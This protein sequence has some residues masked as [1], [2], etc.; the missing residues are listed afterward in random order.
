MENLKQGLGCLLLDVRLPD[1]SGLTLQ[2]LLSDTGRD[3]PIII[4][5]GHGD[6]SMAVKAM[7]QGAFDFIEKP[8]NDQLLLDRIRKA[9]QRD[10]QS[11]ESRLTAD[12]INSL[13]ATLTRRER[14]VM[15]LVVTG[16]SNK[17]IAEQL[18]VSP[19]TVEVHRAH[20]MK[21]MGA[22]SVA[23][24]VRLSLLTLRGGS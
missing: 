14:E 18:Q 23:D 15:D 21:K 13:R 12:R 22:V 8:F 2:Q 1:M 24:L 4:I 16:A 9:L 11:L 6:V 20:M 7:K 5:T 19:K 10:E 17:A 3:L